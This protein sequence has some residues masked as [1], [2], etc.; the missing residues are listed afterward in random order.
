MDGDHVEQ[1]RHVPRIECPAAYREQADRHEVRPVAAADRVAQHPRPG[2]HQMHWVAT[3]ELA[4]DELHVMMAEE[5][6]VPGVRVADRRL[7]VS[8]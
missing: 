2:S 3:A 1:V 6:R 4:D 8:S 5:S 7:A